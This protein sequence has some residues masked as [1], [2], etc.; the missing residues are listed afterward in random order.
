M[1]DNSTCVRRFRARVFQDDKGYFDGF[2][3]YFDF[4]ADFNHKLLLRILNDFDKFRLF[5]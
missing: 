2:C 4:S 5:G 1:A 3:L